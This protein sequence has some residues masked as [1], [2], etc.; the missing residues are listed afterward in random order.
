MCVSVILVL[1]MPMCPAQ[2]KRKKKRNSIQGQLVSYIIWPLKFAHRPLSSHMQK[3]HS[4]SLNEAILSITSYCIHFN[5]PIQHKM[6]EKGTGNRY[7][8]ADPKSG[9]TRN[10][11]LW[12]DCT[13]QH[14]QLHSAWEMPRIPRLQPCSVGQ[15]DSLLEGTPSFPGPQRN[16]PSALHSV[17]PS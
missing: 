15:R 11:E 13:G 7:R 17:V 8:N 9:I 4:L 6:V 3:S 16:L 2:T 12:W 1:D 10:M 5:C 14:L